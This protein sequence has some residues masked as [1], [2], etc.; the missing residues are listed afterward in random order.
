MAKA[1]AE[2]RKCRM[3]MVAPCAFIAR[4]AS[5]TRRAFVAMTIA[6]KATPATLPLAAAATASIL[7]VAATTSTLASGKAV[8]S[9]QVEAEAV[10]VAVAVAVVSG[11]ASA[12]AAAAAAADGGQPF[13]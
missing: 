2:Q 12:A 7:K 10:A 4:R 1:A 8:R 3:P 13:S 9:G 6:A 11:V 5:L